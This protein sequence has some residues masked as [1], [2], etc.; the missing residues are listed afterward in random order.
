MSVCTRARW[1]RRVPMFIVCG[2]VIEKLDVGR[3]GRVE[4]GSD[5]VACV[6]ILR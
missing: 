6:A 3:V 5:G 2:V 4:E 1:D